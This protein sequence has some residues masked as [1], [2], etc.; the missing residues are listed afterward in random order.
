MSSFF[1][2]EGPSVDVAC[3]FLEK[4]LPKGAQII[5]DDDNEKAILS[6]RGIAKTAMAY[7]NGKQYKVMLTKTHQNKVVASVM[8][9]NLCG[10]SPRK[11]N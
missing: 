5:V 1:A 4:K 9:T 11:K 8:L 7:V 2:A 3:L 6:P 10:L